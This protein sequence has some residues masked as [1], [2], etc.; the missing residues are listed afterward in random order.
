MAKEE[1][2]EFTGV[3]TELLP[4][5][6]FRVKLEN[7]HEILAHTAGK[8]RKNRIRVL[9]GDK[10]NVEMTPVRL[11]QRPDHIPLQVST[12]S[13][14]TVA[15]GD[16]GAPPARSSPSLVLASASPRRLQLLAQVGI[17]PELV[18]PAEID[19]TPLRRELPRV[20]AARLALAK[21]QSVAGRLPEHLI[22]AADTVVARGRRI[23]P[24]PADAAEARRCLDPAVGCPP[25]HLRRDRLAG[26]GS[27][28]DAARRRHGGRLQAAV[29]R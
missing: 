23:L 27:G 18:V 7:N 26:A 1:V 11:E 20:Y 8:M 15:A 10:V 25:P 19:E 9:A 4:N 21:A 2:L 16:T 12:R 6:M 22:L 17:V 24:K 28:A 13:R 14:E 3:V 5:A 29:R